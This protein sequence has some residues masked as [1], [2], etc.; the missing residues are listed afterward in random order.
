M[1]DIAA[2]RW[3][4]NWGRRTGSGMGCVGRMAA[5]TDS[6]RNQLITCGHPSIPT[7]L[8]ECNCLERDWER[9]L[10]ARNIPRTRQSTSDRTQL[11]PPRRSEASTAS[12]T[13]ADAS[14]GPATGC[15][16][17]PTRWP[18]LAPI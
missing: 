13:L 11:A 17:L 5:R 18:T 8:G 10:H 2:A 12:D 9:A 1:A 14:P 4:V 3:L 6:G 7:R 16:C 15:C